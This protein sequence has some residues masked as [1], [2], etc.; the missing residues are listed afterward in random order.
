MKI[1]RTAGTNEEPPVRNTRSM[2][3]KASP[4]AAINRSTHADIAAIS[5]PIHFSK[6][7]RAIGLRI[8]TGPDSNANSAVSEVD[9]A[10]FVLCTASWSW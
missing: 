4:E 8:V 7:A 3:E 2:S 6:S 9:S 10:N 1:R 5:S